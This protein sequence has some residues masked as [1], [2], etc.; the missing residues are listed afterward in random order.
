METRDAKIMMFKITGKNACGYRIAL[1]S[2]WM[3]IWEVTKDS[4]DVTISFDGKIIV[5]ERKEEEER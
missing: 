1:P 3:K 4:R 2:A 5:I